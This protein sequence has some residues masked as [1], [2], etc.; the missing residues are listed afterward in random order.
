MEYTREI[1]SGM[2][3]PDVRAA[4]DRLFALGY[5]STKIKVIKKDAFGT[6]TAAALKRFKLKR[7]LP[8]VDVIDKATW[9]ALFAGVVERHNDKITAMR[10]LWDE[11]VDNDSAYVWAMEGQLGINVTEAFIRKMEQRCDEG[12]NADRAVDAWRARIESGNTK[13]RVGDCSGA[14]SF[15]LNTCGVI[16]GRRNCDRLW[17]LCNRI[18][19]P[20]DGAF[21]FRVNKKNAEDETHVGM[22]FDGFQ[23]HSKGRDAG[24]VREPYDPDYWHKIGWF[25]A[26]E[27]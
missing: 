26:L 20:R 14:V 2:S 15:I 4:K 16:A 3:G 22:Y 11:C 19:E 23:Y 9:V 24:W 25:K 5:Y 10:D 8:R 13:F 17:D 27:S 18:Y 1:T 6:D 12:S 7:G 21:L